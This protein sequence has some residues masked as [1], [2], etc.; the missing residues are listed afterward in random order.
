[1][2]G[3]MLLGALIISAGLCSQGFAGHLMGRMMHSHN[4]CGASCCETNC[5]E[6][7]CCD[8]GCGDCCDPCGSC[9]EPVW[10]PKCCR[11]GADL[12]RNLFSHHGCCDSGCGCESSCCDSGCGS[13]CESSCCDS[14]CGSC[15]HGCGKKACLLDALFGGCKKSC[16][17]SSCCDSCQTGCCSHGGYE[18]GYHEGGAPTA[19]PSDESAPVPPAPM[20]DPS[21]RRQ[22]HR[23]IQNASR[24]I[25]N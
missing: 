4:G 8:S 9:C 6:P 25:R 22:S 1:M 20:A 21:A 12:F 2:N 3:K 10:Q 24:V 11:R 17:Q 16:C 14:G 18:G 7:S 5:C 19:A 23:R 15:G 13:C